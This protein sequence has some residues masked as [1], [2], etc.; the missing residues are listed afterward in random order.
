M[1]LRCLSSTGPGQ[2]GGYTENISLH[3]GAQSSLI[4]TVCLFNRLFQSSLC[5]QTAQ[6]SLNAGFWC[7][8]LKF[9]ICKHRLN[10]PMLA[11]L[12]SRPLVCSN[13]RRD[14]GTHVLMC[15]DCPVT[16]FCFSHFTLMCWC[17]IKTA[18]SS[19]GLTV[20]IRLMFEMFL[21]CDFL[22]RKLWITETE[23][24]L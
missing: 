6:S 12:A 5:S 10:V 24:I 17:Q 2:H 14:S 19:L 22:L 18:S 11:T 13:S 4:I 15:R 23:L 8:W 3:L 21:C 9:N 20:A 7:T 16:I 1:T